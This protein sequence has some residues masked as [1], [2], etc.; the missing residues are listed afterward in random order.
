M[1]VVV[2]GT[3]GGI[4]RELKVVGAQPMALSV[5]ITEDTSLK[6]LVVTVG[7]TCTQQQQQQYNA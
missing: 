1:V 5:G 3:L 7:D 2:V 4:H 6:K